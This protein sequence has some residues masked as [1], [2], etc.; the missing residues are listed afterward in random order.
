MFVILIQFCIFFFNWELSFIW[1][2]NENYEIGCEIQF[3]VFQSVLQMEY[4]I[5]FCSYQKM[6][7]YVWYLVEETLEMIVRRLY[8][9]FHWF[10]YRSKV[11]L[12]FENRY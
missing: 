2:W 4:S 8:Q 5:Y 9:T 12:F 3:D 11:K 10:E 1:K 6:H 7:N